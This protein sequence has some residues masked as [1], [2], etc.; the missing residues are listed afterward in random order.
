M[1]NKGREFLRDLKMKQQLE[2][3]D[4]ERSLFPLSD[5]DKEIDKTNGIERKPWVG[6]LVSSVGTLIVWSLI[7]CI[8]VSL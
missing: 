3:F 6:C 2:S 1:A 4:K 8:W 5:K 7:Y